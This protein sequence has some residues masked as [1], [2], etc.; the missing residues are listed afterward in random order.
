ML[1][2]SSIVQPLPKTRYAWYP[3]SPIQPSPRPAT[4]SYP[5][6]ECTFLFTS[7]AYLGSACT[8]D[9]DREKPGL[10]TGAVEAL[11]RRV[12]KFSGLERAS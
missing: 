3:P 7:W 6:L 10:K 1:T 5:H 8:Y 2:P 9:V 12:G 4:N 11:R